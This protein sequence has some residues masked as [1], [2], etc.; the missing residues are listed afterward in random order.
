MRVSLF[1]WSLNVAQPV[2]EVGGKK[3]DSKN[4]EM[5]D[6]LWKPDAHVM[7]SGLLLI[8]HF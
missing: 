8:G 6:A 3:K 5:N 4:R 7:M 2:Q 1:S